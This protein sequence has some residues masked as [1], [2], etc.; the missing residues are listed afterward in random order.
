MKV[1]RQ[2]DVYVKITEELVDEIPLNDFDLTSVAAL[3]KP[4]ADDPLLYY[5]YVIEGELQRYF[6]A[7]KIVFD[8]DKYEYFLC[9]YQ[10]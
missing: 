9:C 4:S 2:I 10:A 5:Q 1:I 7:L 6:E 8:K 3:V